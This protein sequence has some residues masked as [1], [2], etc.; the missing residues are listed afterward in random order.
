MNNG[1]YRRKELADKYHWQVMIDIDRWTT[2]MYYCLN[3]NEVKNKMLELRKEYYSSTLEKNDSMKCT[4][5]YKFKIVATYD[6]KS[7]KRINEN[8]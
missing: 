8:D 1:Y 3:I 4:I 2:E 5:T 7:L 6:L